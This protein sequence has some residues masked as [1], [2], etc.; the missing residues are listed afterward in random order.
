MQFAVSH[1]LTLGVAHSGAKVLPPSNECMAPILF[2]DPTTD[3][4]APW[5]L[6]SGTPNPLTLAPGLKPPPVNYSTGATVFASFTTTDPSPAS[7]EVFVAVGRPGEPVVSSHHGVSSPST[8]DQSDVAAASGVVRPT[9]RVGWSHTV[10]ANG[11]IAFIGPQSAVTHS[12]FVPRMTPSLGEVVASLFI[13]NVLSCQLAYL[14][15]W[16]P[17]PHSHKAATQPTAHQ[18]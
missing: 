9:A 5:G 3:A 8:H 10:V 2:M 15:E 6:L 1:L 14:F 16:C 7:F 18:A 12:R 13:S 17:S 11:I 4:F